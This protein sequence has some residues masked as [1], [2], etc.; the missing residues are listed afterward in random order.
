MLRD[1]SVKLGD[2]AVQFV[3]R[4]IAQPC[5]VPGCAVP[6]ARLGGQQPVERGDRKLVVALVVVR[7]PALILIDHG[8]AV[9]KGD[10]G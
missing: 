8:A 7:Q 3:Q 6:P 4:Q 9:Q 10:D 1:E 2:A 5:V